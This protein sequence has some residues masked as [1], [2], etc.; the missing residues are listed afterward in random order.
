M[1][2]PLLD[3]KAQHQAI[4]KDLL[5]AFEQVL[6]RAH[7]ILGEE[8]SELEAR[9]A[10][11]CRTRHAVGVS[12][13]TDALLIALMALGIG[14][15]DEVITTPLSFFATAGAIVRTGAV[16]VFVDIDPDSF[17]LDPAL[18]ESAVTPRT[19]AVVP[20]HLYGQ[21]A[22]MAPI[23]DVAARY[24]LAVV[25]DAAQALGAEYIDGRRCGSMGRVGC[26]SFFPSKNLGA[27]GDAG[28]VVTNDDAL[29]EKMRL[30]RVQGAK[31]KYYHHLVG[32]N[33][34]LDTLQAAAL[35]VKLPY[36]D[37]WTALRQ[38]HARLYEELFA[39]AGLDGAVEGFSLPRAVYRGG[40]ILHDHI[41]NQFVIRVPDREALRAR[42][43]AEGI[44]TEI[45]YPLPLHRQPCLSHLGYQEGRLP[46][47]ERACREVLAIPIFPELTPQQQET[48][49][50]AIGAFYRR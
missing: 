20:V 6:D 50:R 48:V 13:G 29:A 45:Y 5:A 10:D 11:Y 16:P 25:E 15:G 3:L 21:S 27:L 18:I 17:T 38:R 19:R 12:S 14:P 28:M 44:G 43:T 41:Y 2:V 24:G 40:G 22:D 4:R 32:G 8:V 7:F 37:R 35:T 33:F 9:L 30:L 23:L 47:A 34:R 1:K 42:L 39:E 36:L 46:E 26:L 49:V 31:P